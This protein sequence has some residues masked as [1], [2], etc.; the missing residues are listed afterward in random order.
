M[1]FVWKDIVK[2]ILVS[3]VISSIA[4]FQGKG[5]FVCLFV[6]L[7]VFMYHFA[8]TFFSFFCLVLSLISFL[9]LPLTSFVSF[10]WSLCLLLTFL[11]LLASS[12]SPGFLRSWKVL[13]KMICHFMALKIVKMKYLEVCEFGLLR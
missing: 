3:M 13:G 7:S 1:K 12:C 2:G 6:C 9:P 11:L 4:G 8:L 10:L 5:D